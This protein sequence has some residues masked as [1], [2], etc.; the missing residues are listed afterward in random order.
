MMKYIYILSLNLITLHSL[1]L[2]RAKHVFN[3]TKCV[4]LHPHCHIKSFF[5]R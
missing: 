3:Q 2:L 4:W 1:E 5:R